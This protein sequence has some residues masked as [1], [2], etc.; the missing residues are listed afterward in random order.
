MRLKKKHAPYV[1]ISPFF[2]LFF[3]FGAF[4]ILFSLYLSFFRWDGMSAMRF[5]GIENYQFVL[6][7]PWFW[8]SIYNTLSIAIMTTIPQHVFAIGFAFILHR[9]MVKFKEFFRTAYFL[10]YITAPVAVAMIFTT[11]FGSP[12]G[13]LNATLNGLLSLPLIGNLLE[14]LNISSPIRWLS[15]PNF[16]RPSVAALLTWRF[17][18]WN[19]IIYYAGLQKISNGIYEAAS[20]DG[21]ST[22]QTFFK[23]TLPLLRP[24]MF[25]AMLMSIIGNMQIFDEP[26]ILLGAMGGTNRAGLT[27]AMYLYQTAFG[28]TEFGTG[29]AIA[30]V[31]CVFI[32]IAS[33]IF[34]KYFRREI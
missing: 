6:T 27:T 23:I 5:V 31:L 11:L 22:R 10:P 1:F 32:V 8:Q 15:D 21:A 30:Y 28:W 3:I 7:D 33:I 13:I 25:F 34:N 29:S 17:T 12:F 9:G 18:G 2:I 19:I 20:I 26:I 16:I 14:L 24:I 4:P